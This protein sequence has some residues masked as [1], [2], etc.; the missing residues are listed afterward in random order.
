MKGIL[1]KNS[2][3]HFDEP[4]SLALAGE[5]EREKEKESPLPLAQ[6]STTGSCT[7]N[8]LRLTLGTERSP[9]LGSVH[10]YR[11]A[12]ALRQRF[13]RLLTVTGSFNV[14][15]SLAELFAELHAASEYGKQSVRSPTPGKSE[16][17]KVEL[18]GWGWGVQNFVPHALNVVM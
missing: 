18:T 8:V 9:S 10:L 4:P 3:Q 17:V 12:K 16:R 1:E 14:S 15:F 11:V 7:D 6:V 2:F 13:R 5:R